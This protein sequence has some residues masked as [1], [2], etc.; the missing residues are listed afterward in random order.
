MEAAELRSTFLRYFAD[1]GHTIVPSAMNQLLAHSWPGNVRELNHVIQRA[2]ALANGDAITDFMF[3]P[4]PGAALAMAQTAG[5]GDAVSIPIGTTVDEAT[6]QLVLA[7]I[8]QC[9]GNKLKAARL[10]GIPPR[11]MY[12]HFSGSKE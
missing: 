6:K 9:A 5:N 10:L 4:T 3:A 12:R 7:T 2:V 8:E 11:T 1:N